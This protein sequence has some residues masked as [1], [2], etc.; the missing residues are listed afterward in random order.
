[1]NSF[2]L[3][4]GKT[5][6]GGVFFFRDRLLKVC[7]VFIVCVLTST[8]CSCDRSLVRYLRVAKDSIS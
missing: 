8:G 7:P 2:G 1:V 6:L 4:N 3:V 5:Y